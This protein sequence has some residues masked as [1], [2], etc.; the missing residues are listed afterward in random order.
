[1]GLRV[2]NGTI[3]T[4][5]SNHGHST[6]QLDKVKEAARALECDD[7][8]VRFDERAKKLMRQKPPERQE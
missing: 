7:D 5:A 2:W 6:S 4:V 8:E 3:M 1:M